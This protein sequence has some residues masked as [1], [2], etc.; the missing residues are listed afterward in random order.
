[1]ESG[2]PTEEQVPCITY[3]GGGKIEL[4]LYLSLSNYIVVRQVA[5]FL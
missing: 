4:D 3:T 2:D 5:F 1:M